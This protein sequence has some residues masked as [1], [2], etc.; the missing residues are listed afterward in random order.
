MLAEIYKIVPIWQDADMATA[1]LA[2]DS[3]DMRSYHEATFIMM[4]G[5]LAVAS[6]ALTITSGAT[7][8]ATTSPLSFHYAW[9]GAAIGTAVAGSTASCDVLEAWQAARVA[10]LTLTHDSYDNY[11]LV[12]E[13]RATDMDIANGEYFLTPIITRGGSATGTVD[14]I[15]ILKPRYPANRLPTCLA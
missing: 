4:F 12:V 7:N 6:S 5:T 15:A 11:M 1:T 3:V 13:V 8:A 10:T 14:A 9:G 2:G